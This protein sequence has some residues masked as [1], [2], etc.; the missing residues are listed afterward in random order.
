MKQKHFCAAPFINTFLNTK[1]Q[2]RLCC[3][4]EFREKSGQDFSDWSGLDYQDIRQKM[5]DDKPLPDCVDCYHEDKNGKSSTRKYY[6]DM[7]DRL[8]KP[9]LNIVDGT[10]FGTPLSYDL[11][12]QNLCNLSCRMCSPNASSQIQKEYE[13]HLELQIPYDRLESGTEHLYGEKNI[14]YILQNAETMYEVK[15]LGGEPTIQKETIALLDRLIEVGNTNL[16]K[17]HITTNGTNLN[18]NFLNKVFQFD[19]A[20]FNVSIDA[21]GKA[22]DYIRHG[23]NFKTIIRNV[24][25]I[26]EKKNVG[27]QQLVT[28]YNIFDFWKLGLF[29]DKYKNNPR[30]SSVEPSYIF[31]P[32]EMK[33][34]NIPMK[35]KNKAY[36]LGKEAGVAKR[37]DYIYAAMF[38]ESENIEKCK[39]L[40][41]RTHL[42]DHARKRYI[43]DYL[44][45]CSEMLE[46]I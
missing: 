16:S 23:S 20:Y 46:G 12:F 32:E 29:I 15:L 24:E 10:A 25:K 5:L 2:R 39:E 41:I 45:M 38:S 9:K 44:P 28:A 35:W 14:D 6:N 4:Q 13:E 43:R 18:S 17:L 26:L 1:G 33:I 30:Y 40:K 7:W 22:N 3:A 31:Y 21:Y 19:N 8:G 36:E 37:Y 11:R 27:I 34:Q 42:F